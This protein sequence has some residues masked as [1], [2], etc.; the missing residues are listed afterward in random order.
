MND[1]FSN[2]RNIKDEIRNS[3]GTIA[4]TGGSCCGPV[5]SCGCS[6]ASEASKKVGYSDDD[7]SAAPD[8]ANLGLGCGN[9]VAIASL[10]EGGNHSGSWIRRGL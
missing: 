7:I 9:P 3:Y 6:P 4:R 10:M 5:S 1:K 8:G 2:E